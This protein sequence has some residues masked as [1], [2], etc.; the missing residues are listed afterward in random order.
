MNVACFHCDVEFYI[1]IE[2][3]VIYCPVCGEELPPG[4]GVGIHQYEDEDEDS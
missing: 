1:E 3:A 4:E 2:H